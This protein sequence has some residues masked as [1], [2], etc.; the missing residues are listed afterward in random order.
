MSK[1]L[2]PLNKNAIDLDSAGSGLI[3]SESDPTF[4]SCRTV[5]GSYPVKV[6][7]GSGNGNTMNRFE[8]TTKIPENVRIQAHHHSLQPISL[9]RY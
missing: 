2:V 1:E 6:G 9:K 3:F 8:Y 7:N 4:H 5:S